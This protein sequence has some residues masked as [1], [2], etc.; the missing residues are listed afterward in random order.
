MR[1]R[2]FGHPELEVLLSFGFELF[3]VN[4]SAGI[5]SCMALSSDDEVRLNLRNE[6]S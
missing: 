5:G 1:V 2:G 3:V 6:R 4:C